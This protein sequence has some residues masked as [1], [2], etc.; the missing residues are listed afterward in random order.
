MALLIVKELSRFG[1]LIES[2]FR[3]FHS[4]LKSGASG[5]RCR[6]AIGLAFSSL[7]FLQESVFSSY[8][9]HI[10]PARI[11]VCSYV[12]NA[13]A[14]SGVSKATYLSSDPS[15]TANWY[16]LPYF[17]F[18]AFLLETFSG[19]RA[20]SRIPEELAFRI[21]AASLIFANSNIFAI[22]S[23]RYPRSSSVVRFGILFFTINF[24]DSRMRFIS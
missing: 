5:L 9:E 8:P 10:S 13:F 18:T 1:F 22:S 6:P 24:H 12:S 14:A 20:P 19:A 4:F 17:V 23:C 2:V 11:L 16:I 3:L 7:H 15:Y 21:I